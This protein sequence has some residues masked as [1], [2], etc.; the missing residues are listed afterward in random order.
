MRLN[1]TIIDNAV[2]DEIYMSNYKRA[3]LD[4]AKK[5]EEIAFKN[6]PESIIDVR[7][8]KT[9]ND[10]SHTVMKEQTDSRILWHFTR[11]SGTLSKEANAVLLKRFLIDRLMC[12]YSVG[13]NS[14]ALSSDNN[15]A[16]TDIKEPLRY[17]ADFIS[18]NGTPYTAMS[19]YNYWC[20]TDKKKREYRQIV[21]RNR[22]NSL[23][24]D[25]SKKTIISKH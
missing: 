17:P 10:I 2:Y 21:Y 3:S 11:N 6:N 18:S 19:Y 23:T 24:S 16:S 12:N 22:Y 15:I 25:K 14:F 4:V 8:I 9:S 13:N 20:D 7:D 5:L 1:Y